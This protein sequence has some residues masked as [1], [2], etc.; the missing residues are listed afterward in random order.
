MRNNPEWLAHTKALFEVIEPG[1]D[2]LEAIPY[3]NRPWWNQLTFGFI[4]DNYL[5]QGSD[6]LFDDSQY[7]VN[8]GISHSFLSQLSEARDRKWNLKFHQQLRPCS[9]SNILITSDN[10]IVLGYRGGVN[11]S[12]VLMT[13]PAGSVEPHL[14]SGE[15]GALFGSYDKEMWEELRFSPEHYTSAELIGRAVE[16]LLVPGGWHYYVFRTKTQ[17]TLDQVVDRWQTAVDKKEHKHFVAYPNQF[18]TMLD[19]IKTNSWDIIKANPERLNQTTPENY[20]KILPQASISVLTH[21]IHMACEY[22]PRFA[23]DAQEYLDRHFDLTSCFG[24]KR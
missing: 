16:S 13:L 5:P 8:A 22:G 11:H 6:T 19:V 20:G 3:F 9:I 21:M 23:I 12:D 4:D 7:T 18:P 2:L 14:K 1:I 15:R 24:D 17:M 10:Q